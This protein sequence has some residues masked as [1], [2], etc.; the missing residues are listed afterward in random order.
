[1]MDLN[2]LYELTW[3]RYAL[4]GTLIL[5]FGIANRFAAR[6]HAPRSRT[7]ATVAVAEPRCSAR[8]SVAHGRVFGG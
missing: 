2:G 3:V 1:M 4:S 5:C 8:R 6:A 7:S